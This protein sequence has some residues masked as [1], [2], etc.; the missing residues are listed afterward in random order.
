MAYDPTN[1]EFIFVP[2]DPFF[3]GSD[4]SRIPGIAQVASIGIPVVLSGLIVETTATWSWENGG[5]AWHGMALLRTIV[6][7][8]IIVMIYPF[9]CFEKLMF[10]HFIAHH[11]YHNAR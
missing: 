8:L 11:D 2:L 6:K 4:P 7:G 1:A 3:S 9:C 5:M 10:I